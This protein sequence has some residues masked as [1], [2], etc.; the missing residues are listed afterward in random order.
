MR[1][2]VVAAALLLAGCAATPEIIFSTPGN[3]SPATLSTFAFRSSEAVVT[4]SDRGRSSDARL[5]EIVTR[6][7]VAKGYVPAAAGTEPDF[8]ITYR[9]AVFV[10]ENP[11]DAYAPIRDPGTL[12]GRDVVPDPA[13]SE[14]LVRDATLVLLAV[15]G[16]DEKV[17]WQATASGVAASRNELRN[18][19]FST[20]TA[21]LR[22]FP[23]R[24]R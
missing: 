13:G 8:T 7:L 19:A 2:P 5:G 9:I 23:E 21:M 6:E 20:V 24:Q 12:V 17:I 22:E 18:A 1:L 3:V 11:R 14:G 16:T 15:S 10:H 4:S